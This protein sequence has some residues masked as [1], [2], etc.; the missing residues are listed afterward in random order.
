[1]SHALTNI[2]CVRNTPHRCEPALRVFENKVLREVFGAKKDEIT[3]DLRKLHNAEL[4]AF[5]SS[6]NKIRSLKSRRLRLT[7]HAARMQQ[8]RNA[9]RVSVGNPEG[10]K[11]LVRAR[12]RWEDNIK[13]D[14]REV[15]RDAGV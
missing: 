14:L 13:I 11:P 5:Y 10:K 1:M 7:G 8:F 4:H 12:G 9:Y 2:R 3:G 6:P 15:G